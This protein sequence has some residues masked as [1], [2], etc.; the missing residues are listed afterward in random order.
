VSTNNT[1]LFFCFLS[2]SKSRCMIVCCSTWRK[3]DDFHLSPF[4]FEISERMSQRLY[5]NDRSCSSP[6]WMII[7]SSSIAYSPISK[8]MYKITKEPLFLGSFHDTTIQ[9]WFYTFWKKRKYMDRYHTI[10]H[11]QSQHQRRGLFFLDLLQEVYRRSHRF[12]RWI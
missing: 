5:S 1:V 8:I 6:I 11:Q 4:L 9:I 3:V 7:N 12:L 2:K 10:L